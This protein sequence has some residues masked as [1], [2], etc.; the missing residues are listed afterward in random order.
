MT[1]NA[2][3]IRFQFES[4]AAQ[5]FDFDDADFKR[6]VERA[7][8]INPALRLAWQAWLASRRRY[9]GEKP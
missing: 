2:R 8:Y 1:D 3:S 9:R 4:W 7:E 5:S 6:N